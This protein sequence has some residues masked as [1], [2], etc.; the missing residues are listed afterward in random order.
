LADSLAYAQLAR[1]AQALR[2]TARSPLPALILLTDDERLP[3]PRD[4]IMALPRGSLVI[5]R[6]RK[7]ERRHALADLLAGLARAR[8]L[9]WIVADDPELAALAGADGAH[10]PE[11]GIAHAARWRVR[12][13]DWLITCA[14]HSLRACFS[15]A[16]AGASG[17]LLAPVFATASHPGRVALGATRA[18]FIAQAVPVPLYALGGVDACSA[19]QFAGASLTGLAAVGALAVRFRHTNRCARDTANV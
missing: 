1:A 13:P 5:L 10:F 18:R 12:R 9:K 11:A 2:R 17:V 14:A 8:G 19:R 16:R 15:A 4:S 6:A 7:K 3:N